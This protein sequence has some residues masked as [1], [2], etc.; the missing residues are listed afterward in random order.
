MKGLRTFLGNMFSDHGM[1]SRGYPD[2]QSMMYS[3]IAFP[4]EPRD[5]EKPVKPDSARVINFMDY[6]LRRA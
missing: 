4:G 5:V 6:K 2:A 3:Y 1:F